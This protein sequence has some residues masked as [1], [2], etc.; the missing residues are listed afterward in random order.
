MDDVRKRAYRLVLYHGMVDIRRHVGLNPYK[1]PKVSEIR[2][3]PVIIERYRYVILMA[4][5]LHN[6][7]Y[8]AAHDFEGFDE[9]RFWMDLD[10]MF[11]FVEK[12]PGFDY[13]GRF[14]AELKRGEAG[15]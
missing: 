3:L 4:D 5:A 8:F 10:G 12:S 14:E 13:R 11:E 1:L 15:S 9:A 6:L 2:E 7:A